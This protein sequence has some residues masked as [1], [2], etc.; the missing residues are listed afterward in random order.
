MAI[1]T[2]KADHKDIETFGRH[3]YIDGMPAFDWTNSGLCFS[4]KGTA[5]TLSF[6]PFEK[7]DTFYVLVKVDRKAQRFALSTGNEK[8]IIEGL[9]DTVHK[10]EFIKITEG[11][12]RIA[13]TDI[14]LWGTAPE[15]VPTVKDAAKKLKIEFVGDSLTAGY[16]NLAAAT[17]KGFNT[18]QQDGTRAYAYLC[19]KML[20]AEARYI[21]YSGKG[22][23]NDCTGA[24]SYELPTFFTHVS[25]ATKEPWDFSKWTPDIVVVNAGT[26]D[27][28]GGVDAA[29]FANSALAFLKQIRATYPKA[30]IIWAYGMTQYKAMAALED[31]FARFDDKNARFFKFSSIYERNG[32]VGGNGHPNVKA[33]TRF[34]KQF[35]KFIRQEYKG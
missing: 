25:R 5:V 3:T 24:K 33:H 32:E 4:F 19:A 2:F 21:C 18:Y 16:G 8:V 31:A 22:I 14:E 1:K 35:A 26:N 23:H 34:A 30:L 11:D 27:F 7:A 13:V 15:I 28:N 29:T 20:G 10:L 12:Q 17:E 6:A 9:R